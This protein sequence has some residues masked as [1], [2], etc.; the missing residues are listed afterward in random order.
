MAAGQAQ[1][2]QRARQAGAGIQAGVGSA[3]ETMASM[4]Y[5]KQVDTYTINSNR[6]RAAQA[7]RMQAASYRAQGLLQGVSAQ[8]MY[9]SARQNQAWMGVAGTLLGTAGS[10]AANW[11]QAERMKEYYNR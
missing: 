1:A 2:S 3:A 4:E 11:A 7:A 9:R 8:N 6:V 5:T 10:V